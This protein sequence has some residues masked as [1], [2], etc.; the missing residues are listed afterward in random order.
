LPGPDPGFLSHTK[1]WKKT[2]PR[3]FQSPYYAQGDIG[4][5]E[6]SKKSSDLLF[7]AL[8]FMF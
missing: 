4:N 1:K 8:P 7:H 5:V 2:T 6:P 3:S